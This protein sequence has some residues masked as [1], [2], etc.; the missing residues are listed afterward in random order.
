MNGTLEVMNRTVGVMD[1][2][3][4]EVADKVVTS[5]KSIISKSSKMLKN[6][7]FSNVQS[8]ISQR[9]GNIFQKFKNILRDHGL[10]R[11]FLALLVLGTIHVIFLRVCKL[12]SSDF[13]LKKHR[14]FVWWFQIY[15]FSVIEYCPDAFC[16]KDFVHLVGCFVTVL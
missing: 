15:R 8:K 9:P 3:L 10:K 2:T 1:R 5:C 14:F 4:E 13:F 12:Q 16:R 11:P 7:G 6:Q